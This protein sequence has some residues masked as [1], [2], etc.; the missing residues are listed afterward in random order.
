MIKMRAEIS[1]DD[2]SVAN[3]VRKM[4]LRVASETWTYAA[5]IFAH[6]ERSKIVSIKVQNLVAIT[7]SLEIRFSQVMFNISKNYV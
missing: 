6:I 1:L 3:H 4:L 2:L 7:N 5:N